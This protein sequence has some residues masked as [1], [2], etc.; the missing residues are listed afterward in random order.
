MTEAQYQTKLIKK[1]KERFPGCVAMKND[2]GYQ[3]GLPDWTIL[4][5]RNWATLEVKA[6]QGAARQP[7]QEYFVQQLDDMSFAAVICPENEEEVL[8]ALEQAFAA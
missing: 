4:Y 1:I 7:N 5:K 3:Q 2:S 6:S 8:L